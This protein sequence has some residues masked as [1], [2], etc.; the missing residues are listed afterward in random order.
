[1][2][3]LDTFWDFWRLLDLR[4]RLVSCGLV[5][6]LAV[7]GALEI[8]GMFFL[9]GYLSVLG[10]G[11]SQGGMR[12][13]AD[14]YA[15][16]G[17]G[18]EGAIFA[19]ITGLLLVAV[20]VVKNLLW[21]LSSF[22]L[23]RF[24]MKRYEY[25]AAALFDGYQEMPLDLMRG[26]GTANPTQILNS[27]L[28]VFTNAFSPLL[29]AAADIAIIVAMLVALM[30]AVDPVLVI[31]SGLVLGVAAVLFLGSTR[32]LSGTLGERL[33]RAQLALHSVTAE[34]MRGLLDV[35]LAGRQDVMHERFSA[36]AG[37]FA[38]ASRRIHALG[39]IPRAMNEMVLAAG[40]AI[41]ATWFATREG[42][43]GAALPTL[44]ILGFAGLRV[45]AAVSRFTE[46]LQKIRQTSDA[47]IR[48]MEAL[49]TAAPQIIADYDPAIS[50]RETYRLE[51]SP[52][53]A[54]AS[55]SL[56]NALRIEQVSFS[57]PGAATL[58]VDNVSLTIPAGK[59]V[60]FCG[61]SGGGKSTLALLVMGLLAPQ[62]GCVLCDDWDISRHLTAWH[63]QIGHVG[64]APFLAPRSVR[65]NVAFGLRP[66]QIDD[67][68]VWRALEAAAVAD[69]FRAHPDGLEAI[70]GEDGA[71]LSGGQKQRVAIARA[72]YGDPVVLVFDEATAALD[73]VTEREVSTA[74]ARLRGD[75]TVIVIA[76]RLSTIRQA[77]MIHYVTGGSIGASG[78]YDGLTQS[79]LPFRN[80]T[81][82]LADEETLPAAH[83]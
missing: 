13:I 26:R 74:I 17:Q 80:L 7:S 12:W 68:A 72:L 15:V 66:E 48:M 42:G 2:I 24:S 51:D 65:E 10:G 76:H 6:L 44:A 23:L 78:T 41:A 53:P 39:M 11:N 4:Q 52:L 63:G 58:A 38:V 3:F 29:Q 43:L 34:A 82:E 77:D 75:R 25:V 18:Y 54:S 9:F 30:L 16:V 55:P 59:F 45:T 79:Y 20:F 40:I 14:L 28:Q 32:R 60:A 57:Y 83:P 33:R 61:P 8:V 22:G 46:A 71:L 5:I 31:G 1:M 36:V 73:T 56:K 62:N 70:V 19:L 64:Q 50:R 35:R 81:G 37:S 21:L 69:V 49:E 27:V 47:R 67:A